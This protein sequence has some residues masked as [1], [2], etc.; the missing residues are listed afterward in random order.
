[1]AYSANQLA[2]TILISKAVLI[3]VILRKWIQS[4]WETDHYSNNPQIATYNIATNQMTNIQNSTVYL[5]AI[6]RWMPNSSSIV[7]TYPTDEHT[8]GWTLGIMS[9]D[10]SFNERHVYSVG[11]D[12][13]LPVVSH[14][15]KY[16]MFANSDNDLMRIRFG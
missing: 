1:M 13:G 5:S 3:A 16:I 8:N 9:T 6:P 4:R 10:G 7:Y 2:T 14:D 11:W 15:G 12:M